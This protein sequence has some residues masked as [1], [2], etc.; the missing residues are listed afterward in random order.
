MFILL[1]HNYTLY[2]TYNLN[3]IYIFLNLKKLKYLKKKII[4]NL[5]KKVHYSTRKIRNQKKLGKARIG[6]L[7]SILLKGSKNFMHKNKSNTTYF[8][9]IY[10]Y[11][12]L[13]INNLLKKNIIFLNLNYIEYFYLSY[14]KSKHLLNILFGFPTIQNLQYLMIHN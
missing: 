7:N 1:L 14:F 13:L 5:N 9:K 10:L 8:F 6:S 3:Y 2:Y 4:L 12:F 11:L